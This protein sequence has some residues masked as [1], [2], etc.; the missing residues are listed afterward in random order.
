MPGCARRTAMGPA[1]IRGSGKG[2]RMTMGVGRTRASFAKA[3]LL[4]AAAVALSAGQA[5]AAFHWTPRDQAAAPVSAGGGIVMGADAPVV[6][7]FAN[8]VPL[9]VALRQILPTSYGFATADGVDMGASVNWRGG[10]PW[11]VVLDEALQPLG[12]VAVPG[13]GVVMIQPV[14]AAGTMPA[15]AGAFPP[16]AVYTPGIGTGGTPV[17]AAP[18]PGESAYTLGQATAFAGTAPTALLPGNGNGL[19]ATPGEAVTPVA[20][21]G[22]LPAQDVGVA[23]VASLPSE[24]KAFSAPT[25]DLP[26]VGS[27]PAAPADAG[28]PVVPAQ[29]EVQSWHAE[30]GSTL[31]TV[32]EQW[33]DRAHVELHYLANYDYP[34][35]ASMQV[36]G[37]F[38]KALRTLLEGLQ[39]AQPQPIGQLHENKDLGN[40]VLV[41]EARGNDY[42]D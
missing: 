21:A 9:S 34:I 12:L 33:S 5:S 41:I 25:D 23:K 42:G 18:A 28:I 17:A 37:D 26:L 4:G 13:N 35:Q 6:E 38:K 14:G 10:R 32:L 30:R 20:A 1:R 24:A 3:L 22:P 31:R 16:G 8:Q 39:Y 27:A 36:D 19:G 11:P 29:A 15:S 7:G 2:N 40:S